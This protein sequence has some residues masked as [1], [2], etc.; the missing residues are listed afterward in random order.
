M[1]LF[2]S[3]Q[4]RPN[5]CKE[6]GKG[7]SVK[8]FGWIALMILTNCQMLLSQKA[9]KLPKVYFTFPDGRI[10]PD[11]YQESGAEAT[12]NWI[13]YSDRKENKY[14]SKPDGVAAMGSL[15]FLD[16]LFVLEEK[17][18]WLKV[19]RWS[20][21]ALDEKNGA[22]LNP[23]D[24]LGWIPKNKLILWPKALCDT[25]S[26]I[27]LKA[28]ALVKAT[29]IGNDWK[30]YIQTSEQK[31]IIVSS[32][33]SPSTKRE[34]QKKNSSIRMFR[35]LYVFKME[36]D[37]VLLSN[38]SNIRPENAQGRILG[39]VPEILLTI[40][41]D[42]LCL[43][44]KNIEYAVS[45]RERIL[46]DVSY[47]LFFD[48]S[49]ARLFKEETA[50]DELRHIK[51]SDPGKNK[52]APE[53]LRLPVLKYS[54]DKSFVQTNYITPVYN[55]NRE[56]VLS[57]DTAQILIGGL[58]S[59]AGDLRNTN[60]IFLV[61][62]SE[63]LFPYWQNI[64]QA[65]DWI[66]FTIDEEVRQKNPIR[67]GVVV[68][69]DYADENC[70]GKD[71]SIQKLEPTLRV[72][73][74]KKFLL[75]QTQLKGCA[76][77]G[78]TQAVRKGLAQALKLLSEKNRKSQSNFVIMV[79]GAGDKNSKELDP[80]YQDE[81]ISAL[82]ADV[83]PNFLVFQFLRPAKFEYTTFINQ[84]E[85]ILRKG[86]AEMLDNLKQDNLWKGSMIPDL[87]FEQ[88]KSKTNYQAWRIQQNQNSLKWGEIT[89]PSDGSAISDA[90]FQKEM[91]LLSNRIIAYNENII[92]Q[93][94]KLEMSLSKSNISN[95][96][97]I[98]ITA[99]NRKNPVKFTDEKL[100][101]LFKEGNYQLAIE[102]YAP[103][104]TNRTKFQLYDRVLFFTEAEL[105]QLMNTLNSL[106]TAGGD[107]TSGYKTIRDGLYDSIKKLIQSYLGA[108][109]AKEAIKEMSGTQLMEILLGYKSENVVI[110]KISN[111]EELRKS[112]VIELQDLVALKQQFDESYNSLMTAKGNPKFFF[113]SDDV[114]Y[115]WIPESFFP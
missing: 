51:I 75:E 40:W 57:N 20:P 6:D 109:E 39:W 16:P 7:F 106:R 25:S 3:L 79:G 37:M 90:E 110:Q 74:V 94:S 42:R 62:G 38:E 84:M 23:N 34:Y 43:E 65:I 111:L 30:K 73:D 96:V 82:Y 80:M 101:E 85:N 44:P 112:G 9:L 21:N 83:L 2:N 104:V 28:L 33:L 102:C 1:S 45:E 114:K 32:Y 64:L 26:K 72:E 58:A 86:N 54:A 13:V 88:D 52:W 108:Q 97:K 95:S 71:L 27:T 103:L 5:S 31:E 46:K 93:I 47:P 19:A 41:R 89:F 70:G 24:V 10:A 61:D 22:I 15:G 17:S 48:S 76:P 35:F 105:L 18:E 92:E 107:E 91:K 66:N 81:A 56:E 29:E 11:S 98:A 63:A 36:N 113:K 14:F 100:Y 77:S 60:I 59:K 78:G 67:F 50:F 8:I 4:L 55:A 68:Y 87:T 69:R 12:Q 99:L 115:Y 53:V 49:E